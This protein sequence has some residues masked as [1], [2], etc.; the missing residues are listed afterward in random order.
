MGWVAGA[1]RVVND[2]PL[3]EPRT[4]RVCVRVFHALDGGRLTVMVLGQTPFPRDQ[5]WC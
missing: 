4:D 2:V 1:T 5:R 3:V